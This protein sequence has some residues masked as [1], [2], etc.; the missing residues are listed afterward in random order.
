MADGSAAESASEASRADYVRA[1]R[2]R[3]VFIQAPLPMFFSPL[4]AALLSFAI[5]QWV[6]HARLLVW[7]ALLTAIAIGRV[8]LVYS[9]P[10]NAPTVAQV[11]RWEKI[12]VASIVV[13][14][15]T[16]GFGALTL[17]TDFP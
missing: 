14:D 1:E 17:L 15:L 16:W 10:R 5:W 3:F 4:S 2:V 7:T 12:F 11:R 13:V 8:A 6:P 9:F